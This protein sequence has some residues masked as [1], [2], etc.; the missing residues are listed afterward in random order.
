MK[1]PRVVWLIALLGLAASIEVLAGLGWWHVLSVQRTLRSSPDAGTRRLAEDALMAFPAAVHWS[2]H[3]SGSELLGA[4]EDSIVGALDRLGKLQ[5]RWFPTDPEGYK[6]AARHE[7]L[8]GHGEAA[9]EALEEALTRDPTSPYLN[10]L[11]AVVLR[12]TGHPER[13]LDYMANAE[14]L[15]PGFD[16]PGVE[17]TPED[18]SWIRL[19]GLRRR[20]ELYARQRVDALLNL[21]RELRAR[22]DEETALSTLGEVEAHPTIQLE[23]SQWDMERGDLTS[24]AARA[25][26]VATRTTLPK[27]HRVRAWS[28]LAQARDLDGDADGALAAAQEALRLDPGS[29]A[30]YVAL[31][32][33]A[34]RRQDHQAAFEHLRRA[35]GI[36]PAN[37]SL[38]VRLARAAERA[39]HVADARMALDRAVEVAPDR[40][41]VAAL[42]VEFALRHGDYMEAA[43]SLSRYLDRFPTDARLL[44]LAERLRR[45]VSDR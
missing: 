39:G 8:T 28:L 13:F 31:A 17:L 6:N 37:V 38:L 27:K 14:A 30:P 1:R 41:D 44:R 16:K 15:A 42:K 3:L 33:I 35:R 29:A 12:S 20:V 4:D 5:I 11:T 36:A 40:P 9:M 18:A 32:Y 21:A 10:R 45:E 23:L 34:E 43:M 24:A 2:R 25:E 26:E 22:G 7:L 19:E